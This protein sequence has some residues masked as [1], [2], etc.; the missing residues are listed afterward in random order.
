[1]ASAAMSPAT[2][3]PPLHPRLRVEGFESMLSISPFVLSEP[4]P[5]QLE[6]TGDIVGAFDH[7][8]EVVHFAVALDPTKASQRTMESEQ[9]GG[10][11]SDLAVLTRGGPDAVPVGTALASVSPGE[12][13]AALRVEEASSP[14]KLEVGDISRV[15]RRP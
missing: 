2:L 13:K 11:G 10:R 1:M 8:L 15:D 7:P 9:H 6:H 14:R 4:W 3:D 12:T 5:Y